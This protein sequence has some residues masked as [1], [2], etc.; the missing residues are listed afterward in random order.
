MVQMSSPISQ[1]N[2]ASEIIDKET[3]YLLDV[4]QNQL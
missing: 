2:I 3:H 4:K 1:E